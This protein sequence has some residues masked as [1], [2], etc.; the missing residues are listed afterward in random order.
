[1]SAPAPTMSAPCCTSSVSLRWKCCRSGR[2]TDIRLSASLDLPGQP[3]SPRCSTNSGRSPRGT[4][5]TPRSSAWATT[6]R[7]RPAVIPRN[8]L[9][10]PA[11]YTAYTPYQPEISQGRLEALLNFQTM[12]TDLT[13]MDIANASLLDEGTAAAEAMTLLR[14][15]AQGRPHPLLRRRRLPSRRPSPSS[16]PAPSRWA[17]R[18][19][20]A[21][22]RRRPRR[23]C[24]VR[25][26]APVPGQ[27]AARS[28]TFGR[29]STRVH[30][31][32][33]LVRRGRRP[34]G[35]APLLDAAGRA[36]RRRR[37]RLLAALRRPDGL[38]RPAR[39]LPRQPRRPTSA[40]CPAAWSVS[41]STPPAGRRCAS[42][43]Q[44]RE[45]H[46]RREKAT[47][48]ICTAQ[49]LLAVMAGDVRR[50]P[51][52]RRAPSASPSGCTATPAVLAAGLRAGRR[53]AWSTSTSSTPSPS[54][55][56]AAPAEVHRRGARPRAST[57][58]SIDDDTRR[59]SRSTRPPPD[60]S[61]RAGRWPRSAST[62]RATP[63]SPSPV[64]RESLERTVRLPHPPGL[65]RP[66]LRDRDAALPAARWPTR[67]SPSTAP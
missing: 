6:T 32:G 50:L 37:G 16:R 10:N 22:R 23:R 46:I 18:S 34:A 48:N 25:R 56:R 44:T 21:I 35:P 39:R 30:A 57:C 4:R 66:P 49:V 38:R 43:L 65:P 55:C 29:S 13:G 14:R 61:R 64:C 52:P 45:Q 9:E 19:S 1:M 26:A 11:W 7:S 31:E 3:P 2:A 36:G 51:R 54:G 17:S 15:V 63:T 41:R 40:R 62:S 8:V 12:V 33:G 58:A 27:R 53:R 42:A 5:C 20:S 59:A 60:A 28:A 47:S 67:T 24:G